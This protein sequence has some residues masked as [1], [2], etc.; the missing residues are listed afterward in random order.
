MEVVVY[1]MLLTGCLAASKLHQVID[2]GHSFN[3]TVNDILIFQHTYDNPMLYIGM[4]RTH[5]L[6]FRGNFRIDND[7]DRRVGLRNYTY[8]N[9]NWT[10]EI[11]FLMDDHQLRFRIT[12]YNEKSVGINIINDGIEYDYLWFRVV[13]E[14]SEQVYGLGEQFS[15]LNLREFSYTPGK[16]PE[17][18]S[19]SRSRDRIYPIWTREQ[20]VGRDKHDQVTFFADKMSGAGGDY[21]T[22]YFPQAT[23]IS[24]RKYLFHYDGYNYAEFDFSHNQYHEVFIKG[25]FSNLAIIPRNNMV[26]LVKSFVT[27]TPLGKMAPLPSWLRDGIILGVQ[28]G[29]DIMLKRL[30]TAQ[31]QGVAVNGLWIQDWAGIKN[32]TFG[33]RLFWNWKWNPKRYPGLDQKIKDLKA[34]GVK[35]LA[36][37]NPNLNIEG[38]LYKTASSQG[39]VVKNRTGNPYLLDFGEFLCGIVDLTN[40]AAFN[41]Y[42]GQI[43]TN[44]I[45]LGLSGWMADFGEYLP[46]DAVVFDKTLS[47]EMVHNQWPVLWASCNRQ[48][49]EESGKLGE[50][51]F[52]MRAGAARTSNYT[53]LMWAG[54][55][56]VDFSYGDGLPSTIIAATSMGL[57]GTG[58]THFD[59]G[60]YTTFGS[61]G[62]RRTAEL[63][64]RSAEMAVFTPV[65]RTHEGNQPDFNVQAYSNQYILLQFARLVKIYRMLGNYTN[66]VIQTCVRDGIPAQRPLVLHYQNDPVAVNA[67]YQYMYGSDL[68][69]APVI[70]ANVTSQKVYLPQGEWVFL[71]NTSTQTAG[72]KYITVPAPIGQPPVFYQKTS[73]Y[74]ATFNAVSKIPLVPPP[75]TTN[76]PSTKAPGSSN[77]GVLTAT[78]SVLLLLTLYTQLM[79]NFSI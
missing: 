79:Y 70:Q 50:I 34:Q 30:K 42:K 77:S 75:P 8:Q 16:D 62:L 37:I 48:A 18:F 45:D 39:F 73:P 49:V 78:N 1:L 7:I 51:V 68:L 44:M 17:L 4:G 2:N 25:D 13:A 14:A 21:H 56:N 65:M 24:S 66:S 26:D 72:N 6:E 27:D 52:W 33:Q 41:W 55:Q 63:L 9:F 31:D 38:D 40:P 64:L 32:T 15:H 67:K 12:T 20:G 71:W 58:L 59:I 29:T 19:V 54:D 22:T 11:D 43:K 53:T 60:G 23:F 69:I 36:Y 46:V 10:D 57:S 61:L 5:F 74:S 3:V 35:V 47:I 76:Q 28:G